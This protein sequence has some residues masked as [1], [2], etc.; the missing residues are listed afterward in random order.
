MHACIHEDFL[1]R[2]VKSRIGAQ[3]SHIIHP[4]LSSCSH[5]L[6]TCI[7]MALRVNT[8]KTDFQYQ[9]LKGIST[10]PTTQVDHLQTLTYLLKFCDQ[11]NSLKCP[12]SNLG[13]HQGRTSGIFSSLWQAARV[14]LCLK[15]KKKE[16]QKLCPNPQNL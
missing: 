7:T 16:Q 2:K 4:P 15:K 3:K 5:T 12:L 10:T 9:N 8:E 6:S 11:L 1:E 14:T 13:K